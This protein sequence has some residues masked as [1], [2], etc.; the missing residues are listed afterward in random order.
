[1]RALWAQSLPKTFAIV[2]GV[3]FVVAAALTT[4]VQISTSRAQLFQMAEEKN[5][6]L[7]AALASLLGGRIRTVLNGG[8]E[9]EL[10]HFDAAVRAAMT[11]TRVAKVKL[12]DPAGR[13]VYSTDPKQIGQ[14]DF[15]NPGVLAA[16]Q[17]GRLSHLSRRDDFDAV[18]GRLVD[19]DLFSSYLPVIGGSARPI[20]VFELY[21][22]VTEWSRRV[23]VELAAQLAVLASAFATVYALL[24]AAVVVG[25]RMV[26][27]KHRESLQLAASVARAEAASRTKSEFLANMSHEL[28]TPLNAVIGFAEIMK[29]GIFGQL[30]PP[31]YKE[32]ARDIHASGVHLLGVIN[33]VLE[34][35]RAES[36]HT[37][38]AL[39]QVDV[40]AA[41]EEPLRMVRGKA[42]KAGLALR[43]EVA[44]GIAPLVTDARKLRQIV[45]NL[46][47]NA[48]KFTPKG[49]VTLRV[50]DVER[51]AAVEIA[52]IDTGIGIAAADIP[53]CLAPFGQVD[54]SLSRKH[55]GSGLGLPLS[56]K[57]AEWLGGR[58]EI[59]SELGI[60]TTVKVTLPRGEEAPEL[61]RAA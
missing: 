17:G 36:G 48:V 21:A 47:A 33:D 13:T 42:E 55:E 57:L 34:L 50:R 54:S 16:M 4:Y 22:D 31:I 9:A 39:E 40:A 28:R 59:D 26:A 24:L 29:E 35:A 60:G 25:S 45:I 18:H 23:N 20:G 46:L 19:R 32:Y 7:A 30:S 41:V 1:M 49:S 52:V 53:V 3:V 27:R 10:A 15:G 8:S 58:L 11:G 56:A 5:A 6:S 14:D 44:R 38:L 61:R 12:Y 2:G 37:S 43:A 51:G